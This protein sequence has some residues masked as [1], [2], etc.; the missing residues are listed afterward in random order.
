MRSTRSER[1]SRVLASWRLR[2]VEGLGSASILLMDS[3]ASRHPSNRSWYFP[4]QVVSNSWVL[5]ECFD[6]NTT[7]GVLWIGLGPADQ[8]SSACSQFGNNR[9]WADLGYDKLA[10]RTICLEIYQAKIYTISVGWS[11][12]HAVRNICCKGVQMSP[13]ST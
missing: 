7:F 5:S 2:L 8:Q 1:V 6:N 9:R 4:K 3:P 12:V 10:V 13:R 11:V